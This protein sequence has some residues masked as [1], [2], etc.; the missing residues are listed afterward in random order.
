MEIVLF[1]RKARITGPVA[2]AGHGHVLLYLIYSVVT[3]AAIGYYRRPIVPT[4]SSGMASQ[5]SNANA[6]V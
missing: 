3:C 2:G 1:E 4:A 5:P 6:F